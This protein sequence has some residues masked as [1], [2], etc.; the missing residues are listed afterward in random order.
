HHFLKPY[1]LNKKNVLEINCGTG[2]DARWLG[3]QGLKVEASD[4]SEGMIEVCKQ[5]KVPANFSVCDTRNLLSKYNTQLFDMIFSNF[6]GLNCLNPGEIKQFM[7]DSTELL[8]P[9]G[10]IAAVIMGRNCIWERYYFR[11]KKD[12]RKNRR[13]AKT[14]VNTTIKGEHFLT[15]YYSP[16]EFY[17]AGK[18]YFELVAC[19]PIGLFVPPSWFNQG[20]KNKKGLLGALYFFEKLFPVSFFAD[21][22]DHYLILLQ[23]RA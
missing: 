23:K 9:N 2:E 1:L 20:F 4:I 15:Y 5:K 17:D 14:G 18:E 8:K 12:S 22:A 10:M 16:G 21:K 3:S 6:G 19:K 7:A 11:K 13:L